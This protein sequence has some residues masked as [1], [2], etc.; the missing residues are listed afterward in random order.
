MW[1]TT[2]A[3]ASSGPPSATDT[4]RAVSVTRQADPSTSSTVSSREPSGAMT[5]GGRS[6]T[7]CERSVRARSTGSPPAPR[8][9]IPEVCVTSGDDASRRRGSRLL[10]A[11]RQQRLARD[12]QAL[13]LRGALVELHDLR[14]AHELLDLVLLDEAVAAEDLHRVGGDLHRGVGGEALGV[15]GLDRVALALVEQHRGVPLAEP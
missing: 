6:A 11:P 3:S 13:D 8:S 15:R 2:A 5:F 4:P 9:S 1:R 10:D 7:P 12:D 14:V